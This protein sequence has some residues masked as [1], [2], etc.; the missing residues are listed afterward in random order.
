MTQ[1]T[2]LLR[3]SFEEMLYVEAILDITVDSAADKEL[4]NVKFVASIRDK[5]IACI[6]QA[7][8][9]GLFDPSSIKITGIRKK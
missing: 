1:A 3:L 5:I 6:D 9:D 7:A 8:K 2:K 4:P